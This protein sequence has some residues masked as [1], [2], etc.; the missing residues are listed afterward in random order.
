MTFAEE[1]A[2]VRAELKK[3]SDRKASLPMI[4]QGKENLDDKISALK[5]Q[6]K[7]LIDKAAREEIY[8]AED[9]ART[10]LYKT[11]EEEAAKTRKTLL[12]AG[13]VAGGL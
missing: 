10:D 8:G 3:V 5:A 7:L 1:L 9:L 4:L 13:S 2:A 12:V 11:D 6:E